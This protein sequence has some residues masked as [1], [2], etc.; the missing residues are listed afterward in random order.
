MTDMV[1]IEVREPI[2]ISIGARTYRSEGNVLSIDDG[3]EREVR[4]HLRIVQLIADAEGSTE[5][6]QEVATDGPQ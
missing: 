6:P 3:D 1:E 4:T 5:A 2:E